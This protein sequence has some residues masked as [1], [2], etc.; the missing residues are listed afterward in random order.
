[1]KG[2]WEM[3]LDLWLKKKE[4]DIYIQLTQLDQVATFCR[5]E[6]KSNDNESETVMHK[7]KR[8]KIKGM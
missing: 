2:R 1:M 5:G 8:R 7:E 6:K 3:K 4:W